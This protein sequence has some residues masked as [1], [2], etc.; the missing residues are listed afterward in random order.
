MASD[1]S[2]YNTDTISSPQSSDDGPT[3]VVVVV[4]VSLGSIFLLA[5]CL[6]ALWLVIKRRRKN[7]LVEETDIKRADEHLKVKE[8]IVKGPHG[9]EA[10]VLS[11]EED[12]HFEEEIVKNEKK[13]IIDGEL[14]KGKNAEKTDLE[15]GE[16]SSSITSVHRS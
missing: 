12:K 2:A 1:S 7:K 14:I 4:F 5:F 16:S 6:F 11:I 8:N 3:V 9:L 13:Q 15:V 10:V